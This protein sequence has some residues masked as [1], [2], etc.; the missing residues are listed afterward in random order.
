MTRNAVASALFWVALS[1]AACGA[2]SGL[3]TGDGAA[4][5][6]DAHI[7]PDRASPRD[8][9]SPAPDTP[10]E[11]PCP[12]ALTQVWLSGPCVPTLELG[13]GAPCDAA[14]PD[15]CAAER[16]CDSCAAASSCVS[17]DC[18]AACVPRATTR[19][20]SGPLRIS[21]THGVAGVPVPISIHGADYYVGA[22]FYEFR[23]RRAGD[24]SPATD[25]VAPGGGFCTIDLTLLLDRPGLYTIEVSEYGGGDNGWVLAGFYTATAGSIPQ[26]TVQP[27]YPCDA[28]DVCAWGPGYSCKCIEGRCRC[29]P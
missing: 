1:G 13:C 9:A 10:R 8:S 15:V 11:E 21:P 28:G 24:V 17:N 20:L 26:P 16:R 6:L 5:R 25:L 22:L 7:R 3:G 2:R 29:S 12:C 4:A 19:S 14:D 18:R 27:G 23:V